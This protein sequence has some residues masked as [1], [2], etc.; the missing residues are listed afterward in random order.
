M[1]EL[2][3]F[4]LKLAQ[5]L[6]ARAEAAVSHEYPASQA[7][8]AA[9]TRTVSI[10][11]SLTRS[12]QRS[13]LAFIAATVGLAA[14]VGML[15]AGGASHEPSGRLAIIGD[16][17]LRIID[18]ADPDQATPVIASDAAPELSWS[19]D[20]KWIAYY[21]SGGLWLVR[22][23]GR[24]G[25]LLAT[26]YEVDGAQVPEWSPDSAGIALSRQSGTGI[27]IDVIDVA[28]GSVRT[29]S[30]ADLKAGGPRWSPDGGRILFMAQDGA[31]ALDLYVVGADGSG[32]VGLTD[33]PRLGEDYSA[34]EW[35]PDGRSVLVSSE[36]KVGVID[37]IGSP[38]R[39]LV[40]D[41]PVWPGFLT[42]LADGRVAFGDYETTYVADPSSGAV[43]RLVDGGWLRWSPD[44]HLYG[45]IDLLPGEA[46]PSPPARRG[47]G[48]PR[49]RVGLY[50]G[51]P[52][53][54]G[55]SQLVVEDVRGLAWE[56]TSTARSGHFVDAGS[57]VSQGL[58]NRA[59]TV[60]AD[61]DVLFTGGLDVAGV[62]ADAEVFHVADGTFERVGPM[63]VER[64]DHGA[65]L[66]PDGR[67]LI[68]G[69]GYD[70]TNCAS[71]EL[72]D[73][74]TGTFTPTGP[75]SHCH[76]AHSATLL[77][78]GRVLVAGGYFKGEAVAAAELFDPATGSFSEAGAL[79][80]PRF[81]HSAVRL[82]DGRVLLVGGLAE[83]GS[84]LAS[85]ELYDPATGRFVS[86]GHMARARSRDR[87]RSADNAVLLR[88][89]R[90]LVVAGT[91]PSVDDEA[92]PAISGE[93]E[94]YDT[95]TGTFGAAGALATPRVA[96]AAALLRRSIAGT[97]DAE[98]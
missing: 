45:F 31:G 40:S 37:E 10:P 52:D 23:D 93:A 67:V 53:G 30:P 82:G 48:G 71:A 98:P 11:F 13:L 66:L 94:L 35:S 89:G 6:R 59:A 69:N 33:D 12:G 49:P 50:V 96:G 64:A 7:R 62:V 9:A 28:T 91:E 83:F 41:T 15:G 58:R 21:G 17:G 73:P 79:F 47:E 25:H 36:S 56:P 4:E 55:E 3:P 2:S 24:D 63:G 39:T 44:R 95:A 29:V 32:L 42:W 74:E 54:G 8:A 92:A 70:R 1:D 16:D 34:G 22:P 88:D 27:V 68:T 75:M 81:W 19:P 86:T 5:A 77:E 43:E 14:V 46:Y 84:E 72:Y 85:A 87:S 38:P 97:H 26:G 65:T 80:E 57:F 78:D 61:G 18:L 76:G 20:G 51:S 60:L 90:V